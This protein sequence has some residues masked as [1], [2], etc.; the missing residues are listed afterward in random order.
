MTRYL[1]ELYTPKPAW[2]EL[3]A[4]QRERFLAG[5]DQGMRQL[6]GLGIEPLALGPVE[7]GIAHTSKHRFMGI[8]RCADTAARDALLAGIKASGWY[9]YFA[10]VNASSPGGGLDAHLLA[11]ALS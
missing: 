6:Q 9:G 1:I 8:W 10:H 2:I 7:A 4:E 3:P 5:I 11:L